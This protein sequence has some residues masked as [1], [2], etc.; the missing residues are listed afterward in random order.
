MDEAKEFFFNNE[1]ISEA[2]GP[3]IVKMIMCLLLA[4]I[5]QWFFRKY[6]RSLGSKSHVGSIIPL[7]SLTVFLVN[8]SSNILCFLFHSIL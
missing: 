3:I 1:L 4:I 7:I 2:I 5:L 6:S 8:K